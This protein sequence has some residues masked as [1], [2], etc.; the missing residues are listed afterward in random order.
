MSNEIEEREKIVAETLNRI[1]SAMKCP[2]TVP[3]C[4]FQNICFLCIRNHHL[5]GTLP[6]C[7]LPPIPERNEIDNYPFCRSP[8][9]WAKYLKEKENR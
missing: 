2:C 8:E 9:L 4:P 5:D 7:C 1:K 3:Q 6:A